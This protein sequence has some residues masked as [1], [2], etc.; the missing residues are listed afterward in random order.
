MLAKRLKRN[1]SSTN[2]ISSRII[3]VAILALTISVSAIIISIV[4]GKGL[5]QLIENKITSF[6]G[7]IIISTFDNNN[8]QL[9]LNPFEFDE[10]KKIFIRKHR[11][12]IE[13]P[14]Y[15]I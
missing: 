2:N 5:Q 4:T 10:K 15:C 14:N 7:N 9:S 1:N 8:S 6:N 3:K 12:H 11:K 13:F